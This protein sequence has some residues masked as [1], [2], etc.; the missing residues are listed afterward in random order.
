MDKQEIIKG[1]YN[2]YALA[3]TKNADEMLGKMYDAQEVAVEDR[4]TAD[5]IKSMSFGRFMET[6][7]NES[8]ST[9]QS[10]F[11]GN[12]VNGEVLV[13]TILESVRDRE[14]LLSYIEN[15]RQ[16]VNPIEAIPVE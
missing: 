10:G 9:T 16:M 7:A 3:N 11:G 13:Q 4:L 14:T 5:E 1:L 15:Q 12:F 6:K 8:M 2:V